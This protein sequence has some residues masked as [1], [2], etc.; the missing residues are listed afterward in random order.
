MTLESQYA[1]TTHVLSARGRIR[2]VRWFMDGFVVFW[3]SVT[4]K[5]GGPEITSYYVYPAFKVPT[6]PWPWPCPTQ[7]GPLLRSNVFHL[8]ERRE[9]DR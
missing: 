1:Q 6:S 2:A 3:A 7:R 5:W 4:E 8:P 9:P